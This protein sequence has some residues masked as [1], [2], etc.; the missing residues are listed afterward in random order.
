VERIKSL[1]RSV[2]AD[3]EEQADWFAQLRDVAAD[4]AKIAAG[5]LDALI[6]H[7]AHDAEWA[8]DKIG[9][10]SELRSPGPSSIATEFEWDV[11]VL[12]AR[13]FK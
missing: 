10:L 7:G 8:E 12:R 6:R 9:E 2:P 4:C 3:I 1:L 13:R 11:A 5:A